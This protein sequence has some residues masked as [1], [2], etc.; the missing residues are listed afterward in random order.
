MEEE[1]RIIA[2]CKNLRAR[3]LQRPKC[4]KILLSINSIVKCLVCSKNVDV[5][6]KT[7]MCDCLIRTLFARE[8]AHVGYIRTSPKNNATILL[9]ILI[10]VTKFVYTFKTK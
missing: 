7:L 3:E 1:L 10:N 9:E 6:I 8:K 5:E 4:S 2:D